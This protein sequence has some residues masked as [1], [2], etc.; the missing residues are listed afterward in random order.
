MGPAQVLCPR[1]VALRKGK[2]MPGSHNGE[3][4]SSIFVLTPR[5]FL[6]LP[7]RIM[8]FVQPCYSWERRDRSSSSHWEVQAAVCLKVIIRT[9]CGN[10]K[11]KP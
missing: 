7:R 6:P 5:L 2:V 9:V 1:T 3:R 10:C 8:K 4:R 11:T